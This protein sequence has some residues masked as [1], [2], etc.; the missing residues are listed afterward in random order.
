MK[1]L[2]L[3]HVNLSQTPVDIQAVLEFAD[4]LEEVDASKAIMHDLD[5][6][7]YGKSLSQ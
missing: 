1:P 5:L 7:D 6:I 2:F 4:L 3:G